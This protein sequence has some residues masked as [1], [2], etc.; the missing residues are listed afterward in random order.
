LKNYLGHIQ[1]NDFAGKY[2]LEIGC[3]PKGMIHYIPAKQKLGIDPLIEEYKKIGILEDGDVEHFTGVGESLDF[4]DDTFDMLICFNVLDHS[5]EPSKVCREMFRV[6]KKNG[7]IIF[8]SHSIP[9]LLKPIRFLLKYFDR[10]H[11]WHFTPG[12]LR[13]MFAGAGYNEIFSRI[14]VFHWK[15]RS[16]IRQ[17]A[18]KAIM[19]NYFVIAQKL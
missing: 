12:E 8:H 2:V 19:R 15:A 14:T 4:P 10:P 5:K 6:L 11:P 13:R 16:F 17:A 3:G 18:A 1:F 7:R 9:P